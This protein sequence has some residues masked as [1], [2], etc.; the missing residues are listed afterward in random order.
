MDEKK[1]TGSDSDHSKKHK[2]ER[3]QKVKLLRKKLGERMKTTDS[4]EENEQLGEENSSGGSREKKRQV[5][6]ALTDIKKAFAHI[7]PKKAAAALIGSVT[8]VYLM[9]GIYV[10]NPG[11]QAVIRRLDRKSVV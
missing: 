1:K 5:E 3:L 11:E 9:T 10:V 7:N 8:A 2:I 4:F 6:S